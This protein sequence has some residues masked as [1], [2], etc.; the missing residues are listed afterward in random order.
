MV[1]QTALGR[2]FDIDLS[3]RIHKRAML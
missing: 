3:A 2:F 1:D